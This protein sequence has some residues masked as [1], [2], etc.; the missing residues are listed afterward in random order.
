VA[1]PLELHGVGVGRFDEPVDGE[2]PR[3]RVRLFVAEHLDGLRLAHLVVEK[4][5][6][7]LFPAQALAQNGFGEPGSPNDDGE[8]WRALPPKARQNRLK[9]ALACAVHETAA[10]GGHRRSF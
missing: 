3:Q 2:V 5:H 6:E 10:W 1:G 9:F 7:P 4:D 8:G